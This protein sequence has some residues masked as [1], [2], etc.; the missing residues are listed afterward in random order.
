MRPRVQN[1]VPAR[2]RERDCLKTKTET[3]QNKKWMVLTRKEL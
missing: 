1:P 3:K 2:A